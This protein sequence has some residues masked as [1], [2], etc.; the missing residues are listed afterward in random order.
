[1]KILHIASFR[2][3][4]G[5]DR[6]Y[7][8]ERKISNGFIRNGHTVYDYPYRNMAKY[9][10]PFHTKRFGTKKMNTHLLKIMNNLKPDLIVLGHAELVSYET[11]IAMKEIV[12]HVKIIFW[13]VDAIYDRYRIKH[14]LEIQVLLDAVFITSDPKVIPEFDQKKFHYLPNMVDESI[15]IH[16]NFEKDVFQYDFAFCAASKKSPDRDEISR[17]L[18]KKLKELNFKFCG[19]LGYEGIFGDSYI[20][21]LGN[22][23][24]GLNYSKRNDISLYSSDRIAQLTGNGILT[25]SPRIPHFESIY[26]NNEIVYYDDPEDLVRKIFYYHTHDNERKSIAENGYLKSHNL[27]NSTKITQWMIDMV[28]AKKPVNIPMKKI[29]IVVT[30]LASS[31][32]EKVA[33]M[34]AKLFQEYGHNVV[35]FMIDN[36][37]NYHLDDCKFPIVSLSS[38]K[39]T[40]KIFGKFGDKIYANILKEKMKEYGEFDLVISNLPRADRVVK[41][42]EHSNKY[43]VIHTSYKTELEKISNGRREDKKSRLY[44]YLYKEEKII[45][46]AKAIIEDMDRMGIPYQ[47]AQTIYNPFSFECIRGKGAEEIDLNY[48]YIVSPTAFR[49]EKR[50]DVMLDAFKMIKS[51]IRLVI[52]AN[53]DPKLERMIKERGLEKRVVILGFQQNPYKYI[54]RAKLLVLSSEREGLPTVLIESLILGTP[55]VSTDCPTGPSEILEGDLSRWLVPV[56]DPKA[57]AE[58]IDEALE[59]EIIIDEKI[60]DKFNKRTVYRQF[61]ALL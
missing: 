41:L 9:N 38:G 58:K 2:L 45:T 36:V 40:Y 48:D 54:K 46:V 19:S 55:V 6:H 33:L 17:L 51:S 53:A 11:I 26:S 30:S 52:L 44:Q 50:Y 27:Y 12:P 39:D 37:K 32:A 20:S 29:A 49:R 43:F 21:L 24:M 23:K 28:F 22:T 3:F 42:L 15:E 47:K 1:M 13:F 35:L 5:G 34:Q 8:M 14:L 10:N 59:S 16:K 56:N 31:G 7:S 60:L 25:F 18:A 4:E 61:E 57:L